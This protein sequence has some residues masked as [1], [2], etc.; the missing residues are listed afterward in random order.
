M[1]NIYA[2][3]F[4]E[5]PETKQAKQARNSA[6][7]A[8][9]DSRKQSVEKQRTD[10]VKMARYN[11]LG[12]VLTSMVQPLGWAAGGSSAGVQP[13]DNRQYIESFNRAV[14]ADD[15]L[16][17]I[18]TAEAEYKFN[19][20]DQDYRRRLSLDDAARNRAFREEDIERKYQQ[21]MEKQDKKHQQEMDKVNRQGEIRMQIAEFN[22]SH[23]IVNRST[24]LS[25]SEREKLKMIDA[26][27]RYA[28]NEESYGRTPMSYPEFLASRGF[29]ASEAGGGSGNGGGSGR[30]DTRENGGLN[31]D[32]RESGGLTTK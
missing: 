16:R 13:Y 29:S 26:Y 17:N 10:D 28:T 4:G 14:K 3:I 18:G 1:S 31:G 5:S 32:G 23:K 27:N 12:N 11:A 19:L 21:D 8:M 24:G 2:S 22:A 9:L 6:F 15:D 25:M 30:R 7:Q 20:A